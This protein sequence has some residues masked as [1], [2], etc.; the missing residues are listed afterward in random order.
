MRLSIIILL[1]ALTTSQLIAQDTLKTSRGVIDGEVIDIEKQG[2]RKIYDPK[3]ATRR[4]A[5][6]P[7][8]GQIYNDS[9]WKV[10]ILYAGFGALIY[11]ID[12]NQEQFKFFEDL[13]AQELA[14][15]PAEQ[16]ENAL[17]FYQRNADVWRKN[18]DLVF[19]STLGLYGL[20]V[21]EATIDAHL[22]GFNVNEELALNIKPKFGVINN[23]TPYVGFGITL[24]IGK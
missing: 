17:R 4:S 10:P 5:I 24:P 13:A 14:K 6:I 19:L 15:P 21:L 8:W 11:Y 18:R 20:Q 2:P 12:F 7:G 9:W 23:G 16:D 1:V 22:K 3:V